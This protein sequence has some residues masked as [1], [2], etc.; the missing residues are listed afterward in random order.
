VLTAHNILDMKYMGD[1]KHVSSE[2]DSSLL[3][4]HLI[5]EIH[6]TGL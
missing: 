4:L 3:D 5:R 2:S 6:P 1:L